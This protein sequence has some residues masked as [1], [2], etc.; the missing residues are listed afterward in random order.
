MDGDW[1]DQFGQK[2]EG[3][4]PER[5]QVVAS[6]SVEVED[7]YVAVL[8]EFERVYSDSLQSP[9]FGPAYLSMFEFQSRHGYTPAE[10]EYLVKKTDELWCLARP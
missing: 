5:D 6:S 7:R 1:V 10:I 2:I 3:E 4:Q 9:G 8:P